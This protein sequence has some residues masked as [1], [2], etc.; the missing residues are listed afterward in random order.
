MLSNVVDI[1]HKVRALPAAG[2]KGYFQIPTEPIS[3]RLVGGVTLNH[4]CWARLMG[5]NT[6][7]LALQGRDD[8]G[9]LI[10]RTMSDFGVGADTVHVSDAHCTSVSHIFLDADGERCIMMSPG[11]TSNIDRDVV[12]DQ[13]AA[14][15]ENK[16]VCL[17]TTEI[18]Q[19]PLSGVIEMLTRCAKSNIASMVDVDV[20]PSVAVREAGLGN[21]DEL[22]EAIEV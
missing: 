9:A 16:N 17:F 4:L 1:F 15:L 11:S 12:R 2:H 20:P 3:A 5:A 19:V 13:F 6:S 10:R 7:L 14:H 21:M 8:N 18:S 22:F